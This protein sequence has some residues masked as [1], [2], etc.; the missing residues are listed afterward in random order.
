MEKEPKKS[1]I[2]SIEKKRE[3]IER[4]QNKFDNWIDFL[5]ESLHLEKI[6]TELDIGGLL[7]LEFE[8]SSEDMEKK[9]KV[10]DE[11]WH[12]YTPNKLRGDVIE[13]LFDRGRLDIIREL[14]QRND[15]K[16]FLSPENRDLVN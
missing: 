7:M 5:M 8:L 11:I 9:R 3:E 12:N 10:L 16:E 14:G 15:I 13:F 4:K 6:E 1:N 2:Y